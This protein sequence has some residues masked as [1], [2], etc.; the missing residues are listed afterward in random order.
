MGLGHVAADDEQ[1]GTLL[2]V[3]VAA[4]GLVGAE[5]GQVAAHGAGH[6]ESRV[7]FHVIGLQAAAH[8]LLEEIGLFGQRLART[9][10]GAG[11]AAVL[12]LGCGELLRGYVQ[13]LIPGNLLERLVLALA[14]ERHLQTVRVLHDL[15]EEHALHAEIAE[16]GARLWYAPDGH[17]TA[18]LQAQFDAATKSAQATAAAYPLVGV[19]GVRLPDLGRERQAHPHIG[20]RRQSCRLLDEFTTCHPHGQPPYL[21]PVKR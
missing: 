6:A 14:V 16:V 7:A 19:G 20:G 21:C 4:D 11:V 10:V 5:A 8:D 1:A 18:A 3:V 12:L 2:H 13:R 17:G 9:V 15:V